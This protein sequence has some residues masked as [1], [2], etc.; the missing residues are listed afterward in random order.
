MLALVGRLPPEKSQLALTHSAWVS[1]RSESYERL[2]FLGDSVLGLAISTHLYRCY[3]EYPEGRLAKLKAYIVSRKSCSAVA[4]T[5][6]LDRLVREQAPG[7]EAQRAE[8]ADNAAALGNVLE[9]L[10]GAA[11]LEF[12]YDGVEPA[13]VEAFKERVR[14][15]TTLHVD[16]KSTLQEYLAALHQPTLARYR[17]IREEGPPHERTFVSQVEV[18]GEVYGL[19]SGSSIK[20]SEQE[21]AREALTRLGVLDVD[22][23]V[24]SE[25]LGE[26][27]DS[28]QDDEL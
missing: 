10:I 27:P 22:G 25:E 16:Y 6:G 17:L 3:P 26:L 23:V 12:G 28:D 24:R 11:F 9:A 5:L 19:G 7:D 13:V 15:A 2:E 18:G 4:A 8:L 21:S 14:Y 1:R 20:E